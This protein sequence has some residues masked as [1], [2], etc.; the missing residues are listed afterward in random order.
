ML[1]LCLGMIVILIGPFLPLPRRL[2]LSC[3]IVHRASS[4]PRINFRFGNGAADDSSADSAG[5]NA[6]DS[7]DQARLKVFNCSSN[8]RNA[9]NSFTSN[10]GLFR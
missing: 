6:T 3:V 2:I 4:L 5:E 7:G 9:G 8:A 10:F 1:E